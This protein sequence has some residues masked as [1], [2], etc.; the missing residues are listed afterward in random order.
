[1]L[2]E[3]LKAKREAIKEIGDD[4]ATLALSH[5]LTPSWIRYQNSDCHII[6]VP[7]EDRPKVQHKRRVA[8]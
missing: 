2:L 6:A 4:A 5:D 1:M 8:R 3:L 7:N